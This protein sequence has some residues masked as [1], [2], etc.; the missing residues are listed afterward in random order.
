VVSSVPEPGAWA[1]MIAGFF[2]LG[3]ML[4]LQRRSDRA[5]A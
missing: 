4:R 2:G 1:M 5:T 3:A